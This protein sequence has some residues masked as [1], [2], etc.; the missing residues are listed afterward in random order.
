MGKCHVGIKYKYTIAH[1]NTKTQVQIQISLTCSPKIITKP[2]QIAWIT[3]IGNTQDTT[4]PYFHLENL[5]W[6]VSSKFM[7][8]CITHFSFPAPLCCQF[9]SIDWKY[10]FNEGEDSGFFLGHM[11]ERIFWKLDLLNFST[12]S[13][14]VDGSGGLRPISLVIWWNG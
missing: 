9:Y 10:L 12:F 1:T 7:I 5:Q 8:L 3:W 2:R 13:S 4:S 6:C 11:L 14:E